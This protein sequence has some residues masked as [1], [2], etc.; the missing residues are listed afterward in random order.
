MQDRKYHNSEFCS[1]RVNQNI[2]INRALAILK[3]SGEINV[4][5]YQNICD[6]E[7]QSLQNFLTNRIRLSKTMLDKFK[8]YCMVK[9]F[10]AVMNTK[11]LINGIVT[12]TGG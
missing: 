10:R 2:F 7:I 1:R 6:N 9:V 8:N 11:I 3:N 12:I 4:K 5:N